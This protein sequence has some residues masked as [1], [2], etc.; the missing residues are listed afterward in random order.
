MKKGVRG[1]LLAAL[2]ALSAAAGGCSAGEQTGQGTL[3][4]GV[5]DDIMN[6]G[7]QNP[8]TGRYYGFEIDLAGQLAERL[9]YRTVEF[10]T[11]QPE[12]RKEKLLNGEVDCL[13]AAYSV[14]ETR[15]ENFDFSE[16]YYRDT[17]KV[18]VE[19]S[20]LFEHMED[21]K[22]KT[23][24]VL[25]GV[26]A[27]FEFAEEMERLGLLTAGERQ[28]SVEDP[29]GAGVGFW[30]ADHYNDLSAALEAGVVD[31]V[32]MDGCIAQSYMQG[33]RRYLEETFSEQNYA[34]ATQKGSKLSA[35]VAEAI[36]EMLEDG[37]VDTLLDK[38]D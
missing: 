1:L 31:A 17:I 2:L 14:T 7:Y 33:E 20:T 29:Y 30:K 8:E 23:V 10:V 32:C 22:G 21:L 11:V 6:F 35:P 36:R 4:V 9:G 3:R 26:N 28:K 5:R 12:N 34:V 24:G 25:S 27:P 13:I 37:T 19:N 16:P 15:K 38:W 18:M